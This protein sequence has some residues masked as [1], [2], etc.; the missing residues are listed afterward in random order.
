MFVSVCVF[1]LNEQKKE[2]EEERVEGLIG[3]KSSNQ[4]KIGS[5]GKKKNEK[6]HCVRHLAQNYGTSS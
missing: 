3:K 5:K 6:N 4:R 2:T 1:L